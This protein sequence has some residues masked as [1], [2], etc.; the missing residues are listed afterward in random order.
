MKKLV[1]GL[2]LLFSIGFVQAQEQEEE[3]PKK[4]FDTSKL[5]IGGNLGLGFGSSSTYINVSP[6]LGYR[7]SNFFAAGAGVNFIY[8]RWKYRSYDVEKETYGVAGLNVFG[9]VYPIQYIVVQLQPELNYVWYKQETIF[10]TDYKSRDVVPSL[11]AGLGGAIPTGRVGAM[12]IMAQ[13]DL[14]H[15]SKTPYG[16]QVFFSIGYNVG[17]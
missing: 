17:L 4:G 13:Y 5:F 3:E 1:L 7:F 8:S 12:I 6:Q 16:D 15:S 10:D 2:I 9:R 11:L 14:L